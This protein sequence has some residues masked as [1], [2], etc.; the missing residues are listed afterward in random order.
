MNT[1]ITLLAGLTLSTSAFAGS[2]KYPNRVD[3]QQVRDLGP[4]APLA[5][6]T[7]ALFE[8]ERS[9]E[10]ILAAQVDTV[11]SLRNARFERR[12]APKDAKEARK[13]EVRWLRSTVRA[14]RTLVRSSYEQARGK[15]AT[16]ETARVA[17]LDDDAYKAKR[18]ERQENRVHGRADRKDARLQ[19]RLATVSEREAAF[20]A[21]SDSVAD[22]E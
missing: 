21:A 17:V 13:L 18:F 4:V 3:H 14:E 22:S 20:Q 11:E 8:A 19:V 12:S 6:A 9:H 2:Y 16:L 10:R 1:L 15:M 5:S 7:E